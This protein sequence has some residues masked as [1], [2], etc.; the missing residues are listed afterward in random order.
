MRNWSIRRKLLTQLRARTG[1]PDP[2][3]LHAS[4]Q[5]GEAPK[6]S[7][8]FLE[9]AQAAGGF[10]V[11]ELNFRSSKIRGPPLFFD[12]IGLTQG[13]DPTLSLEELLSTIHPQDLEAVMEVLGNALSSDLP[14]SHEYR[15]IRADG[16]IRWLAV[17]GQALSDGEG[18]PL[19]IVGTITDITDR[20][21]LE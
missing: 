3:Q 1:T 11:F 20:K 2:G 14:Y 4:P 7:D 6:R 19:R 16:E 18:E 13:K 12:L 15:S 21:R 9:F 10:G 17:R 8:D 5:T